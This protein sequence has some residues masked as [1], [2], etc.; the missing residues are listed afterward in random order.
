MNGMRRYEL[1]RKACGWHVRSGIAAVG[2]LSVRTDT[3]ETQLK[4]ICKHI[5]FE[6]IP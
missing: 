2:R 1:N 4:N 5:K 6:W 3:M